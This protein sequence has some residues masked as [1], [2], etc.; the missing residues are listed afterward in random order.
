MT[1][2]VENY[3]SIL[4]TLSAKGYTLYPIHP[5]IKVKYD[6]NCYPDVS[7][8]PG[9]VEGIIITVRPDSA[10]QIIRDSFKKGIRNIWLQQGSESDEAIKFCNDN[11]IDLVS[12]ECILMFASPK[13]F[14]SFHKWIWK[15]F[16]LMKN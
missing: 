16:K 13:G 2:K 7:S 11:R 15:T 8:L 12:K 4:K 5:E 9:E 10:L 14:H 1:Y 3:N 6:Y